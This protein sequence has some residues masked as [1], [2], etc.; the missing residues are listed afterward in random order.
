MKL[1]CTGHIPKA[2]LAE[3]RRRGDAS[4]DTAFS[5]ERHES[6]LPPLSDNLHYAK[7]T[8]ILLKLKN[9]DPHTDAQQMLLG[10]DETYAGSVFGLLSGCATRQ[11]GGE[12]LRLKAGDWV[13]FDDQILHCV[14]ADRK[15]IGV[16]IQCYTPGHTTDTPIELL[17]K[18]S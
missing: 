6:A 18:D 8:G 15:W 5:F 16:A 3:A 2:L 12:A 9:V 1:I 11:V 10:P 14:L 7:R 4:F 17:Q 13:Y